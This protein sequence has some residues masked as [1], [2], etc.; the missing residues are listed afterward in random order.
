MITH[1]PPR[2]GA[3]FILKKNQRLKVHNPHGKQVSDM[4]L[5]NEHD[6]NEKLSSGKT[7]DYEQ[8]LLIT[9]GNYIWSNRSNKMVYIAEDTC[10]RNDFLLAPC[11]AKTFTHFY[12]SHDTH[13]SCLTNLSAEL[14]KF[15]V[16]QDSIPTAF[17]L[18]MN[19]VIALDG[20]LSVLTP[21]AKAG[22]YI[23]LIAQMDLIVALTACSAK[24]S[25]GGSFK[26]I[27]YQVLT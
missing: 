3:S 24:D 5:I 20:S 9:K 18:F 6:I 14:K 4:I 12:D 10:G 25:N 21:I 22:D 17:N 23:E 8:T 7:F 2:E 26:P 16:D 19:V 1:I 11:D 27:S 13:P 15:G